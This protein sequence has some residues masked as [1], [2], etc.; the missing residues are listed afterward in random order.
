VTY[1]APL[2]EHTL[3]RLEQVLADIEAGEDLR[4]QKYEAD[5]NYVPP[6]S[7]SIDS[8]VYLY[9]LRAHAGRFLGPLLHE[10]RAARKLP[11]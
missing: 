5:E 2:N 6:R 7:G 3:D 4:Q 10:V 11:A 1:Y 8:A 9:N